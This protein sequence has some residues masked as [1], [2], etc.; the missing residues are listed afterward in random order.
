[1]N[2]LLLV[3]VLTASAVAQQ[4]PKPAS[5]EDAIKNNIT[6]EIK[7]LDDLHSRALLDMIQTLTGV[8]VFNMGYNQAFHTVVIHGV[9]PA[10]A[11]KVVELFKKYDVPQPPKPEVEFTAYL[12][13]ATSPGSPA[14]TGARPVPPELQSA[15]TQMKQTLVDRTYALRDVQ[16][17]RV[18]SE[19]SIDGV[20]PGTPASVYNLTYGR[21]KVQP[22]A[23][24]VQIANFSFTYKACP[25][26]NCPKLQMS[27]SEATIREGQKLVFGKIQTGSSDMYVVL[28]AKIEAAQQ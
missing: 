5:V 24:S 10:D 23:K 25:G 27:T 22:D 11:A 18:V 26:D 4:A 3:C 28:T 12:V 15:I 17:T 13:S 6:Y 16:V 20:M 9:P 1:M 21:I 7:N 14:P 2:K 8:S 19:S